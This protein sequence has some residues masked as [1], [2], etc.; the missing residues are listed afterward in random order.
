MLQLGG[1]ICAAPKVTR[2]VHTGRN[3]PIGTVEQLDYINE[4]RGAAERMKIISYDILD[5]GRIEHLL[6]RTALDP[7]E[8]VGT[9]RD[10]AEGL[11][12]NAAIKHHTMTI[13]VSENAVRGAMGRCC[14]RRRQPDR[15]RDPV[16]AGRRP[17]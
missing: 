12:A 5:A 11:Q 4:I 14:A 6:D 2:T 10:A 15:Q 9:L 3:L 7:V 13:C 8:L 1:M 16:Y 17:D